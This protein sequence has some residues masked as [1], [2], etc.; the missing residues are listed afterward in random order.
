MNEEIEK[1][2]ELILKG[3]PAAPGIAI[4]TA[5]VYT[6][7]IPQVQERTLGDENVEPEIQ[8]LEHAIARADKELTKILSFARQKLGD[9]KAKIFEAQLMIVNDPY[10]HKSL[11]DRIRSEKKNAEYVVDTEIDKYRKL[12]MAASDEYMHERAQEVDDLKHR[13]IRN[14]QEEKLI[15]RLETSPIIVAHGLTPADTMIL[16]R[17]EPLGYATDT[18]GITSH[19][20]LISRSLKLPAVVG[21]GNATQRIS[22]GDTVVL[23]GYSGILVVSPSDDRRRQYEERRQRL[24]EFEARLAHLK[25][26]PAKT[27]DG[28]SIEL[29]ANIEFD[30]E[31]EFVQLQGSQG[32]GLY[33]TETLLMKGTGFPSEE[34]QYLSYKKIADRFYPHPVIL[35]TFDI[36]GDKVDP[37]GIEEENPFLGWRGIRVSLDRP[38]M[39]ITQLQAML[40]AS[41]R[42]NLSIMFPMVTDVSEIRRAKEHIERAKEL[43]RS[44]KVRFNPRLRVGVM[45]ETPA[46]ALMAEEIAKEVDF[47]SIGTNDLIQYT[48]A[49]DRGNSYVSRLYQEFHPAMLRTVKHIIDAG[50]RHG[51]WVGMCGEMAGDPIAT[52]LL[53][54]MGLDE[55]SVIPAVLPEIKKI[56]RSVRH[57]DARRIVDRVMALTSAP[58]V[59]AHLIDAIHKMCP[60]IPLPSNNV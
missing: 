31:I 27:L 52:I 45:I 21:L 16:S 11:V 53:L 1:K 6:K 26:L 32:I 9:A 36:G 22:T 17:N 37:E 7:T 46:A 41:T 14:L 18:G 10:L 28:H 40:R 35:R 23:D 12:M 34:E 51:K 54:G 42:K 56:I 13:I 49:V 15:S 33:R 24:L 47:L 29:S 8:R 2:I 5:Y 3:V 57:S 39:F 25:D 38:E 30:E 44:R 50:H 43:L 19:A 59:E 58:D 60:D 4:G 20:S 55:L 48:L